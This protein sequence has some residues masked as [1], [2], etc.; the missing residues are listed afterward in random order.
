MLVSH[1][2]EEIDNCQNVL[3]CWSVMCYETI[4]NCQDVL[5][6]GQSCVMKR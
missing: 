2:Y 5:D 4:D 6:V 1:V 3:K